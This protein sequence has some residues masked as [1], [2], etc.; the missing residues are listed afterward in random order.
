MVSWS[1]HGTL[2]NALLALADLNPKGNLLG[3]IPNIENIT[4]NIFEICVS[5][6]NPNML[7]LSIVVKC[8]KDLRETH[9]YQTVVIF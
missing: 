7:F 3:S 6:V 5:T 1:L 2:R 8:K 4:Q 9:V